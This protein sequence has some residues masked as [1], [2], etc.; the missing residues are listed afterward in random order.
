[1]R[2]IAAFK[3]L[4]IP[5]FLAVHGFSCLWRQSGMLP[6]SSSS[7]ESTVPLKMTPTSVGTLNRHPAPLL[8]PGTFSGT[9][10][11][12]GSG[13]DGEELRCV[14]S[15]F[16]RSLHALSSKCT[17]VLFHIENFANMNEIRA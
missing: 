5:A 1:M 15:L 3:C 4:M 17:I 14:Q 6:G 13:K 10:S 9:Q 12:V 8:A 7:G 16:G 2:S 11:P